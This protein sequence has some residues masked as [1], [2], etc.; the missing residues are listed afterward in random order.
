MSPPPPSQWCLACA[1]VLP[2][3]L[4]LL[5]SGPAGAVVCAI[6]ARFAP[7]PTARVLDL[8]C[9][10]LADLGKWSKKGVTHYV[11][12]D[13]ATNQLREVGTQMAPL[14]GTPEVVLRHVCRTYTIHPTA[15][16]LVV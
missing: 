16:G 14:L 8:A 15:W 13:I 1:S 12:V 10:K 11:G 9:G 3:R 2:W 5:V 7:T 6:G 4:W